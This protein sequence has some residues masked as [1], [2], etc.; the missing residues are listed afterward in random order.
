VTCGRKI[1]EFDCCSVVEGDAAAV[2]GK[3]GTIDL[4]VTDPP[5]GMNWVSGRGV[6]FGSIRGDDGSMSIVDFLRPVVKVLR[7]GRHIYCFGAKDFGDLPISGTTELIWDKGIISLGNLECPWGLSHERI[8]F[9][10]YNL[11]ASDR[12]RGGGNLA[13][14]MRKKSVLHC[15]RLHSE[16]VKLHPTQKPVAILR[17]LIESSSM[18]GE[19]VFDPYC[20]SG[21]TLIAA[22][23]EGRH[24]L[25]IDIE[26]KYCEIARQRLAEIPF[27]VPTAGKEGQP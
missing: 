9:G 14:R 23:V 4:L 18:I 12:K 13:A 17:E 7:R 24:F 20:G 27:V 8:L 1:G 19:I 25:G 22:R 26:P 16:A 11:S 5:Y 2:S 10:V 6:Q 3:L 15:D 21:S